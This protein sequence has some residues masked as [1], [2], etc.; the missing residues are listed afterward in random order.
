MPRDD[1]KPT[2]HEGSVL[3]VLSGIHVAMDACSRAPSFDVEPQPAAVVKRARVRFQRQLVKRQ[4][5]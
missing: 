3:N 1:D 5:R 4:A 2:W